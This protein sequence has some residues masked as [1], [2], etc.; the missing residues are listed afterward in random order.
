MGEAKR[1]KLALGKELGKEIDTGRISPI[2]I[3]IINRV[4]E[5]IRKLSNAASGH[6]G[7]D[8]HTHAYLAHRLLAREGFITRVASGF[9][10]WRVGQGDGDVIVHQTTPNMPMQENSLAFHSWL[11]FDHM[12]NRYILDMTTYQLKEKAAQ[13]DALD[14]GKTTVS[15]A[16]DMLLCKSSETLSL[17]EVTQGD[18]GLFY[19][20]RDIAIEGKLSASAREMMRD[21]NAAAEIEE[22]FNTLCLIYDQGVNMVLGPRSFKS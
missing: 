14:G 21:S 15:W 2:P 22:D 8:C 7:M 20:K 19:Y 12:G 6:F 13:L 9:A 4:A 10:A 5:A 17:G 1:K 3:D 16:P 11:E 18:V